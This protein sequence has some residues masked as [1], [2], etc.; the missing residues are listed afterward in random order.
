MWKHPF[1]VRVGERGAWY[2]C[3]YS[4]FHTAIQ[5]LAKPK[6]AYILSAIIKDEVDGPMADQFFQLVVFGEVRYG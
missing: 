3:A 6:Y 2:R 1:G 4:N 5:L